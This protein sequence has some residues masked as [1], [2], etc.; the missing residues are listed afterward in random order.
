MFLSFVLTA[1]GIETNPEKC[2]TII[3]MRSL[4]TMQEVQCLMGRLASLSRFLPKL[5]EKA[6]LI[7]KLVKKSKSFDWDHR[8]KMR[9]SS[10]T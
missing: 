4:T 2:Q 9:W 8:C 3:G 1:G 5:A 7:M 6:T 10:L